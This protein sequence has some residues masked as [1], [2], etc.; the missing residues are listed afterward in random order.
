MRPH[1]A[2]LVAVLLLAAAS[3]SAHA[4]AASAD[5]IT[6]TSASLSP[7][8]VPPGV[9]PESWINTRATQVASASYP[10]LAHR[11]WRVRTFRSD[12]DYFRTRFS[13]WRFFLLFPMRYYVEVNPALFDRNAPADGV[14]AILAHELVHVRDLSHGNRL[15][16]L[17]LVRLL[18]SSYT[19]RFERKTD[20]EAIHRGYGDGLKSYRHWIYAHIPLQTVA[21]KQRTYFTPQEITA[22]QQRL[23]AQPQLLNQWRQHVPLT[24]A[25][26][27]SP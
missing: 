22:L 27:Q 6:P 7:Q 24:L 4:Q 20:L 2:L 19:V 13:V 9:A 1:R 8:D 26:I 11:D 18:S 5:C 21:R 10:E 14:C 25:E 12:Y 3:A 17:G 15:R 16:L 23:A